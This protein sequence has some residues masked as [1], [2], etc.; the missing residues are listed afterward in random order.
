M[1]TQFN[2]NILILIFGIYVLISLI[3][4]F[5]DLLSFKFF[6]SLIF[7]VYILNEVFTL[8]NLND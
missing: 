5:I 6:E 3:F 4:V 7:C 8:V 2:Y 1:L